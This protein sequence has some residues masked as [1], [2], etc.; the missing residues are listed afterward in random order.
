MK[1]QYCGSDVALPFKCPFCGGYF[2]AE[3]RLPEMH[4]CK[5][6]NREQ[7]KRLIQ[8]RGFR[9]LPAMKVKRV[10]SRQRLTFIRGLTSFTEIVHVA[11][12][13][14][15]VMF[16]G[17]S[18]FFFSYRSVGV[19]LLLLAALIF[20]LTF[21]FHEFGH[22]FVAIYSGL[23][24]EFR[25]TLIGMAITLASIILPIKIVSPGAVMVSGEANRDTIG[26]ISFSGP[27]INIVLSFL[28]LI[29][30]SMFYDPLIKTILLWGSR[31]NAWTALFNLIPFSILDGAKIF[32]WNKFVWFI[33][34]LT[35]LM[36]TIVFLA[37]F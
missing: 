36:L 2:C 5:G 13:T 15:A 12:G 28:F 20:T 14:L 3:H 16:V 35:S 26:K 22:K 11:L 8:E 4:A 29:L 18:L 34:F 23:W 19:N 33:S 6:I 21:M 27:L 37:A 1:C 7:M 31:I 10:K 30:L 17:L 32:W 9:E 25:L 24:A